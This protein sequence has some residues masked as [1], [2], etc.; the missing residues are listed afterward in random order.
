MR[1]M[2]IE[3]DFYIYSNLSIVI[4]NEEYRV[5]D[6]I[7]ENTNVG[8]LIDDGIDY[9]FSSEVK[10]CNF[11]N[12]VCKKRDLDYYHIVDSDARVGFIGREVRKDNTVKLVKAFKEC[13]N[14]L[15]REGVYSDYQNT[16][17]EIRYLQEEKGIAVFSIAEPKEGLIKLCLPLT[18][19]TIMS[20]HKEELLRGT[21]NPKE[22]IKGL[23]ESAQYLSKVVYDL[24]VLANKMWGMEEDIKLSEI[25]ILAAK[26]SGDRLHCGLGYPYINDYSFSESEG[27]YSGQ[28][29]VFFL[30]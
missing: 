1:L 20:W 10:N 12:K 16:Y 24:I 14:P 28:S 29:V 2:C 9:M 6:Y 5:G 11:M 23:E 3:S 27:S 8:E 18:G 26:N 21:F 13:I 25:R 22:V 19:D 4:D 30:V 17:H 7:P 15:F